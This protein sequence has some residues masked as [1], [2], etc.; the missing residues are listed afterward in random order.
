MIQREKL[1]AT[2]RTYTAAVDA[3]GQMHTSYTDKS[4][5]VFRK[6][7]SQTMTSDARYVDCEL[8]CLTDDRSVTD[9]CDVIIG[10]ETY[11]V[12]YVTE[13]PRYMVLYLR[14]K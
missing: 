1:Q 10:T 5:E 12:K 6:T 4:I 3:Y 9:Q 11:K 13:T 14:R 8:M 7:L 2:L